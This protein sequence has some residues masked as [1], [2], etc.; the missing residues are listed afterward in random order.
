MNELGFL[1]NMECLLGGES[2]KTCV[3]VL[4]M[5]FTCGAFVGE[6]QGSQVGTAMGLL[7]CAAIRWAAS[8]I[9]LDSGAFLGAP[10]Q[11]WQ[12][13][14]I[15]LMQPLLQLNRSISNKPRFTKG[16]LPIVSFQWGH[17]VEKG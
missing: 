3:T 4:M 17:P 15:Y 9:W 11:S 8:S 13:G 7:H 16:C 6:D 10:K 14:P 5:L 2:F 1:T 12:A